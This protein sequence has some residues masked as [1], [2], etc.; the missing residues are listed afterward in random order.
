MLKSLKSI[1]SAFPESWRTW[2]ER[3]AVAYIGYKFGPAG[4]A[5]LS[6]LA[7]LLGF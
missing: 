7:K 2:A 4:A 3:A 1:W 5:K 6:G